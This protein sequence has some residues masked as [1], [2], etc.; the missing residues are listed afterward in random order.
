MRWG[1]DQVES[2]KQKFFWF[3]MVINDSIKKSI[4]FYVKAQNRQW[5]PCVK[6][7][8][9]LGK[10]NLATGELHVNIYYKGTEFG[11]V[12]I[13]LMIF[14]SCL[15]KPMTAGAKDQGWGWTAFVF[16]V[17]EILGRWQVL[18]SPQRTFCNKMLFSRQFLLQKSC[19]KIVFLCYVWEKK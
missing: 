15:E 14:T 1:L 9:L 11:G 12:C 16:N 13:I 7:I 5:F 2:L 10:L 6:G 4:S 17:R 18:Y 19:L 8:V 3:K